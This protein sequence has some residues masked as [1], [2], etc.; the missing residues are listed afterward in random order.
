MTMPYLNNN[1]KNTTINLS[2]K[3]F[4]ET[5]ALIQFQSILHY[6]NAILERW[7]ERRPSIVCIYNKKF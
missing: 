2:K 5:L 6:S 3:N 7:I 1:I 4:V